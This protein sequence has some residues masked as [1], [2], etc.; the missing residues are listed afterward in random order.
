MV[1]PSFGPSNFF[2]NTLLDSG[3]NKKPIFSVIY[4]GF[5][6]PFPFPWTPRQ[7][8]LAQETSDTHGKSWISTGRTF[9]GRCLFRPQRHRHFFTPPPRFQHHLSI[10]LLQAH[11]QLGRMFQRHAIRGQDDIPGLQPRLVRRATGTD[12]LDSNPAFF[13]FRGAEFQAKT[14]LLFPLRS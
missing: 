10:C 4:R 9:L 7:I 5:S 1:S 12:V 14:I 11:R 3:K 8:A 13:S 6:E 2:L